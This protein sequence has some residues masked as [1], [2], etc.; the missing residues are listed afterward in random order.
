[1]RDAAEN[2]TRISLELGGK[3]PYIVMDDADLD[4][5]AA[6]ASYGRFFNVAGQICI[7]AERIYVQEGI[8]PK[9]IK[10]LVEEVKKVKVGDPMQA[11]VGMGP[12]ITKASL[13]KSGTN[14]E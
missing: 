13:G 11:D 2:M 12:L 6:P 1:M 14:G 5:T 10:K 9:F 7:G 3:A 8:A 4:L